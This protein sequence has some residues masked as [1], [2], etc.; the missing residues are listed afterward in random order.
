[1]LSMKANADFA[2]E[3]SCCIEPNIVFANETIMKEKTTGNEMY[4]IHSGVVEIF[5]A[6][7][8]CS[9]YVAIGDGCVSGILVIHTYCSSMEMRHL[10]ILLSCSGNLKYFGEVAVLLGIQRTASAKSKTQ[11]MLY[12]LTK[13][14]LLR[15]L[16]DYPFVEVKMTEI[17]QSRRRRLAHYLD[18]K[19]VALEP[20]D[21]VDAEDCQTELFGVDA[22]KI[23]RAKEEEYNQE[24][25]NKGV[26]SVRRMP[27]EQ[28][29]DAGRRRRH[30]SITN[31]TPL[32]I[33]LRRR[34]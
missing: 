4:F 26:R 2:G 29:Q 25:L 3:V 16:K 9:S 17:A 11:C 14:K 15:L 23:L 32:P 33:N 12:R 21:E 5:V 8:Q 34:G 13:D 7:S 19:N 20:G 22:D 27:R 24:R 30:A 28:Q 1:M 31:D 10:N 18:P 6:S